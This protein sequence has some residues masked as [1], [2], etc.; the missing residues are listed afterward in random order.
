MFMLREEKGVVG[1]WATTNCG[2]RDVM[3]RRKP[4]IGDSFGV[5]A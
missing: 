4:F 1:I 2:G 3:R 5:L